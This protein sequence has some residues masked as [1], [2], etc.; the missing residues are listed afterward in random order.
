MPPGTHWA[1]LGSGHIP[2]SAGDY[3]LHTRASA[4][5][6][7][8]GC[9]R[10]RHGTASSTP[11]LGKTIRGPYRPAS[12]HRGEKFPH[13]GWP[14]VLPT[15]PQIFSEPGHLWPKARTHPHP[16]TCAPKPPS[17]LPLNR[18]CKSTL[19][20]RLYACLGLNSHWG[21]FLTPEGPHGLAPPPP[22]TFSGRGVGGP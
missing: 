2:G 16:P 8:P 13:G 21:K 4:G 5:Q 20:P 17:G 19:F 6:Q 15:K 9:P 12:A 11:V 1:P 14:T 3:Q 22:E 7:E 18:P 10:H